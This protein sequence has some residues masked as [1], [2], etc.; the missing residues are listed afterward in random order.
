MIFKRGENLFEGK[1]SPPAP[2]F[3]NLFHDFFGWRERKK[4]SKRNGE[5][6]AG[7]HWAPAIMIG[8]FGLL[9]AVFWHIEQNGRPL[10]APTKS[11][12]GEVQTLIGHF[13]TLTCADYGKLLY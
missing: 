11:I 8:C 6:N 9:F 7:A 3:Q 5:T 4:G 13:D 10:V 12:P 2:L 1:G